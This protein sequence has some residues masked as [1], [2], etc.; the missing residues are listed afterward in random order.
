MSIEK[1]PSDGIND[2]VNQLGY[3]LF[4]E[5]AVR[6]FNPSLFAVRGEE[7]KGWFLVELKEGQWACDCNQKDSGEVINCAH[8]YAV[9]LSVAT[10]R[11]DSEES[12]ESADGRPMRCRYCGSPDLSRCG[13]RYNTYGIS[14]RYRCNEC[15]RKFSVRYSNDSNSN[16]VPSEVTWLL[17][18]VGM[19]LSRLNDL[20]EKLSLSLAGGEHNQSETT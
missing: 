8:V 11:V 14:R 5:R 15:L 17:S 19:L 10:L 4:Q 12:P 18:E 13:F 6:R 1:S 3:R 16:R 7:G 2:V 20:M 9:L